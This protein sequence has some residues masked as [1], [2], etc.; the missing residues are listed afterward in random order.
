MINWILQKNLTKPAI[1]TRIKS[2]QN[3]KDEIWEAIEIVPFSTSIPAI[4]YKEAFHIIYGSTTFM[5][6]AYQREDLKQGV[7][8]DPTTFQMQ[9]YVNQWKD[10][11]LNAD[12]Q[13]ISF[14][15]LT[16]L[17]SDA[18]TKWFIRP[19]NDGKS[20]SGR[21]EV[22]SELVRWSEKICELDIPEL[23]KDTEVWIAEPRVISKEWRLFIVDDAI[24]SVSRY[25]HK[26][27]LAVSDTDIP[28]EL[29]HFAKSCIATYRLADVYVMDIAQVDK[30]FKLIECNCFNGTG[31]YQHNIEKIIQAVNSF[32]KNKLFD[33][34]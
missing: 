23:N 30:A 5:L 25:M 21:V 19:N 18:D 22:F 31:F 24:V 17:E 4:Q 11:V 12:G 1:L 26:G 20:F 14:G 2:T 6:N 16:T 7:F 34:Y 8:F 33:N 9:N 32:V 13:L 29:L 3:G 15:Q 27:E 28:S 10:K